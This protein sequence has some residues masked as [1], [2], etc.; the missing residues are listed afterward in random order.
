[1]SQ[2][3]IPFGRISLL[4]PYNQINEHARKRVQVSNCADL[5]P[6]LHGA[7]VSGSGPLA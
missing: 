6:R 2:N 1:M 4:L 3:F 7:C 5:G